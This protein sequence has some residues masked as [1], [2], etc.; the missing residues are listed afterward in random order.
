LTQYLADIHVADNRYRYTDTDTD[1][2][3]AD[4][5]ISVSVKISAQPIIGLTLL[6]VMENSIKKNGF[7]IETFPY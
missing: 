2:A 6:A 1:I 7:F 3:F 4:T 5:D